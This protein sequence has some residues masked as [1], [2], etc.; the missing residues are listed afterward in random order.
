METV[1]SPADLLQKEFGEMRAGTVGAA[2]CPMPPARWLGALDGL[3]PPLMSEFGGG[4]A[5]QRFAA[6]E[7][8]PGPAI[9]QWP[10]A[11]EAPSPVSERTCCA[12]KAARSRWAFA[13]RSSSEKI[14][15]PAKPMAMENKAGEV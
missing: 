14:Q 13:L 10:D 3:L 7:V 4:L 9:A 12:G 2:V 5:G 11:P 6:P 8:P 1:S 15:M